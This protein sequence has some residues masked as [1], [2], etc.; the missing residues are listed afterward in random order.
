MRNATKRKFCLFVSQ[1]EEKIMQNAW[2]LLPFRMEA[3]KIQAE[4]GH[5]NN[6]TAKTVSLVNGTAETISAGTIPLGE[7]VVRC[8]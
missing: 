7:T 6:D 4:Q 3:K 8:R 1:T 2:C 5:F